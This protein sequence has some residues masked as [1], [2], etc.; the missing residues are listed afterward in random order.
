M[1]AI[2]REPDKKVILTKEELSYFVPY[3]KLQTERAFTGL[4]SFKHQQTREELFK[5]FT[6]TLC[7]QCLI[8]L[9]KNT[10][11]KPSKKITITFNRGEELTVLSI[12]VRGDCSTY[13]EAVQ[14]SILQQL[15]TVKVFNEVYQSNKI[16]N[17]LIN[18]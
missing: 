2:L 17:D 11:S 6:I 5:F 8:K 1:Q 3:L 9:I 13:I 18:K 10:Q 12:F 14:A 4:F 7:E 15:R 16:I